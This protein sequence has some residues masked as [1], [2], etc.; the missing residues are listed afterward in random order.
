MEPQFISETKPSGSVL[1][2]PI[3]LSN[4]TLETLP[5]IMQRICDEIQALKN[6]FA[7]AEKKRTEDYAAILKAIED[8][9][10][11]NNKEIHEYSS[12]AENLKTFMK[13]CHFAI[14]HP[15]FA[16]ATVLL[17]FA[18]TDFSMRAFYWGIWPK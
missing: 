12:D 16:V 9:K 5:S 14:D 15:W 13:L 17:L 3:D 11:D 18:V 1:V 2:G 4:I 10:S 6:A 7:L 8:V